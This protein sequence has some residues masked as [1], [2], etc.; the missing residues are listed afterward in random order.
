M[1][2]EIERTPT[3][4]ADYGAAG[5]G[6]ASRAKHRDEVRYYGRMN[7][8]LLRHTTSIVFYPTHYY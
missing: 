4:D 8:R 2:Y 1:K 7:T 3:Q 6:A 5:T